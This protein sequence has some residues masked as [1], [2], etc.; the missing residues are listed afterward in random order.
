[1][2]DDVL[3][4]AT[5]G[6]ISSCIGTVKYSGGNGGTGGGG[7]SGGGGGG[8]GGAGGQ[9]GG[10]FA[11][12]RVD[13][14]GFG[15]ASGGIGGGGG[16]GGIGGGG[17]GGAA[18]GIGINGVTRTNLMANVQVLVRDFFRAVGVT[19]PQVVLNT[20]AGGAIPQNPQANFGGFGGAG[21]NPNDETKAIAFNER[22]GVLLVR[23]TL[24]D[25]DIIEQAIQILNVAPP[26]VQIEAKFAEINQADS[27]AL[28]FDWYLGNFLMGNGRLG[29]QAGSAPAYAGNV[30]AANPAGQFPYASTGIGTAST[31]GLLTSGLRN[32]AGIAGDQNIPALATFSGILTDPQFRTVIRALEQRDGVELLS[33]PKVTTLSGRQAQVTVADVR[34]IVTGT[35][36]NSGGANGGGQ[37]AGAAGGGTIVQSQGIAQN[38]N[39][40]ALPFGPTLDVIPYVSSDDVSIQMTIMPSFVE[41]I[42][43]EESQ[44][45]NRAVTASGLNPLTQQLPLP[46]LRVRQITTSANVWDGQTVVLGG[47]I[48]EDVRKLK[49]KIPV[50]GD[51]PF[52]GRLFRNESSA[53]SKKNL[54]VFVTPTII[55][56]AGKRV[57]DVNNMPYDPN[58]V[59]P[60]AK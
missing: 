24:A 30:S 20:G 12:P 36:S 41:F 39:T 42:G 52:L 58:A 54:L 17:A 46:H 29:A 37:S 26:M 32:Q 14:S 16:G 44:F 45:I 43:Y 35:Q 53:T 3:Q 27:K 23:A 56:P 51:I 25:L 38:Y 57:H 31:D 50:L 18:G 10:I 28:G 5:G 22:A 4:G 7:S 47:L 55:D 6:N 49:D 9:S 8:A 60:E 59:R 21:L 48:A 13:L 1:V 2:P 34:T 33:A 11:I 40:S 19:F 15:G